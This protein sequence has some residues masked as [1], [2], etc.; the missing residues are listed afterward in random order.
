MESSR[1]LPLSQRFMEVI[2]RS[3]QSYRVEIREIAKCEFTTPQFRALINL[4]RTTRS[5]SELARIIGV[6]IPAMS[7]M[8]DT[9]VK[10]GLVVRV[11]GHEDR[12]QIALSLSPQGTKKIQS[13]RKAMQQRLLAKLQKLSPKQR[14]ELAAGL[15]VLNS[16]CSPEEES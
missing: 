5:N 15:E 13:L 8:V 10:R 7:R 14:H 1:A 6:S 11:P 4:D 3:M 12:R 2:P 9:L 16:L